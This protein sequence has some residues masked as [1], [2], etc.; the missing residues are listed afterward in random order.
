MYV[1]YQSSKREKEQ[2]K[3]KKKEAEN[4][5]ENLKQQ[6][7]TEEK[8]LDTKTKQV[9]IFYILTHI[10]TCLQ[11]PTC[12]SVTFTILPSRLYFHVSTQ[13][14]DSSGLIQVKILLI[15]VF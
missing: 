14:R 4:E 1:Q 8:E 9:C 7:E 12:L 13:W 6:L 10:I 15:C 2:K 11:T 3:K 5:A